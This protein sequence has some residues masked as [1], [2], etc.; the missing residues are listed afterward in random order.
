MVGFVDDSV[1]LLLEVGSEGVM[2][3]RVDSGDVDA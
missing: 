3:L 2:I 1:L